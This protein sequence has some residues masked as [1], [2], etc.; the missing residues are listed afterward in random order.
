MKIAATFLTMSFAVR[1]STVD[2][3][4]PMR[5]DAKRFL[6]PLMKVAGALDSRSR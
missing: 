4:L 1:E 3:Y 2:I 6:E 5:E